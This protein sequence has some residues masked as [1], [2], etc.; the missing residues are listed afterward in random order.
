MYDRQNKNGGTGNPYTAFDA[1][2]PVFHGMHKVIGFRTIMYYPDDA[3]QFGFGMTASLGGDVNT[4]WFQEVGAQEGWRGT[5]ANGH[6]EGATAIAIRRGVY[7]DRC[8]ESGA[9]DL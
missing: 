4:A 5:Y 9:V 7:D 3:L 6:L 2:W 8:A 1:W